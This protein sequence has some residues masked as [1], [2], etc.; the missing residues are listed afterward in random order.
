MKKRDSSYLNKDLNCLKGN[1]P[2]QTATNYQLFIIKQELKRLD[3]L[4]E[5]NHR[6]NRDNS[7]MNCIHGLMIASIVGCLLFF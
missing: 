2:E 1:T 5:L 6:Y 3:G 7:F 4:I